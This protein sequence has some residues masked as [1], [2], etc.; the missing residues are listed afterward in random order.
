[1]Y[2]CPTECKVLNGKL[3]GGNGVCDY[4]YTTNKAKCF[5]FDGYTGDYCST[6][7]APTPTAIE[8]PSPTTNE[9]AYP[10]YDGCEYEL[11][12]TKGMTGF[13]NLKY[14]N[15]KDEVFDVND[16]EN[17]DIYAYKFN[18]CGDIPATIS[19]G[20]VPKQCWSTGKEHG[21][22]LQIVNN[23][24]V[25]YY[26]ES[27][28]ATAVQVDTSDEYVRCY[29]LATQ[30]NNNYVDDYA[31]LIK[32]DY[33]IEL[34][35][36]DNAGLGVIFTLY[37]GDYCDSIKENR[38]LKIHLICPDTKRYTFLPDE[39]LDINETVLEDPTCTYSLYYISPLACP[40]RCIT[41]N[42]DGTEYSVC[43]NHGICSSDPYAKEIHCLC[44]FGYEG[45]KC[46]S[47]KSGFI[48]PTKSP[49]PDTN[50][51][52]VNPTTSPTG[53]TN[54]P[55]KEPTI[56][57]T[58]NPSFE[59]T[60]KPSNSPTLSSNNPSITPSITPTLKPINSDAQT[61]NTKSKKANTWMV[62]SVILIILLII[63]FIAAFI[64]WKRR[65]NMISQ[66]GMLDGIVNLTEN[67]DTIA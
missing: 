3:C 44:D 36:K 38:K 62:L 57:P 7:I 21:P 23:T 15:L 6:Q 46:E 39:E 27:D 64:I 5:C 56:T 20:Q 50:S 13:Y 55:T 35:D 31:P 2:G 26:N 22:C 8:T 11:T 42:K 51:P 48:E 59:T 49:T 32:K 34:Y 19:P 12:D 28:V 43:S 58:N 25:K 33:S 41:P 18:V 61:D 14:F 52:S 47:Q 16:K 40:S 63:I 66:V 24:C 67:T 4:D 60:V 10:G 30:L 54:S 29:W 37:N 45:D 9:N 1:M 17:T 53:A 65:K